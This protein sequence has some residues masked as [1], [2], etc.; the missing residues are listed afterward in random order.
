MQEMP[1]ETIKTCVRCNKDWPETL[2]YFRPLSKAKNDYRLR[3]ICRECHRKD[4]RKRYKENPE[5][6]KQIASRWYQNNKERVRKRGRKY[7]LQRHG[8]TANEY[9]SIWKSQDGCCAV[10]LLPENGN[11]LDIDHNHDTGEIRGLLCRKCNIAIGLL[12]DDVV[13]A[14]RL[15]TYVLRGRVLSH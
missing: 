4:I 9:E 13:R 2:E 7:T 3:N 1:A 14:E 8:L 6:A 5:P 15:I 11:K 12:D 10:C